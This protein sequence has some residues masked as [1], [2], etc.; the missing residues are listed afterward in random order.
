MRLLDF[1]CCYE[2]VKFLSLLSVLYC[3][4]PRILTQTVT[5]QVIKPEF[6]EVVNLENVQVAHATIKRNSWAIIF[7]LFFRS[8]LKLSWCN[9]QLKSQ[10]SSINAK[11]LT[12]SLL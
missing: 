5:I 6:S 12:L 8:F 9:P 7:F 11:S 1:V 3:F 4:L 2:K 10:L